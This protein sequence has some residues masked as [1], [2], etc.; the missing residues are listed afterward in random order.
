MKKHN[1]DAKKVLN[2]KNGQ[3]VLQKDIIQ[4]QQKVKMSIVTKTFENDSIRNAK[5]M[6]IEKMDHL[7]YFVDGLN[8]EILLLL[9]EK[10]KME[11][12]FDFLQEFGKYRRD[13]ISSGV[14]YFVDETNVLVENTVDDKD[15]E[16]KQE[17][18]NLNKHTL[19]ICNCSEILEIISNYPKLMILSTDG[20]IK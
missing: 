14:K 3:L 16:K 18:P 20:K 12:I 13:Q 11:L 19:F 7:L 1:Y 15:D 9:M 17:K 2:M 6:S 4:Q 5:W 8:R 10:W